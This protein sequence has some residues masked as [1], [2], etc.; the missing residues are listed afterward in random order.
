MGFD[1]AAAVVNTGGRQVVDRYLPGHTG[2]DHLIVHLELDGEEYWLDPTMTFQRGRLQDLY[3][4]DYGYAF[5]MRE[6]EAALR[7]VKPRGYEV[8]VTVIEESFTVPTMLGG[9]EL[10]VKTVATGRD[11][12]V[13]RRTFAT[14]T[15]EEVEESYR[16]FYAKNYSEIEVA[17]PLSMKD[18]EELNRIEI[19]EHY[20]IKNFWEEVEDT[21]HEAEHEGWFSASFLNSY[22]RYPDKEERKQ[23]YALPHHEHIRHIIRA[24]LP[25]EWELED[26]SRTVELPSLRGGFPGGG[27]PEIEPTGCS[28]PQKHSGGDQ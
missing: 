23:P 6:G 25:G 17:T 15:W 13:L 11:A 2:F 14:E 9:A 4:P 7:E 24:N 5:V 26:E 1:A 16:D 10:H 21:E 20:Q 27:I 3:T 28:A 22:L 8:D 12:D 18:D 19:A